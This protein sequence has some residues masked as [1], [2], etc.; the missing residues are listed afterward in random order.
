MN[1]KKSSPPTRRR[2]TRALVAAAAVTFAPAT[3]Q[4]QLGSTVANPSAR[5]HVQASSAALPNG[6]VTM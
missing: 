1:N 5:A 4:S 6:A 3:P 2:P